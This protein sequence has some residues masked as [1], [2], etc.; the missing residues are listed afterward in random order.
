MIRVISIFLF[1]FQSCILFA[2]PSVYLSK[3]D[4][5][6]VRRTVPEK[7]LFVLI[8]LELKE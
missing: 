4:N 6:F 3:S 8:N 2:N 5:L 1:V 7:V